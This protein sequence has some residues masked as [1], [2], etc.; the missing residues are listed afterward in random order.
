[1]IQPQPISHPDARTSTGGAPDAPPGSSGGGNT[2]KAILTNPPGAMDVIT[3]KGAIV[4]GS[5]KTSTRVTLFIQDKGGGASTGIQVYC[6]KNGCAQYAD[7][8]DTQ[9]GAVVDVSGKYT[10]FQG[11]PE[12]QFAT[13]TPTGATSTPTFVEVDPAELAAGVDVTSSG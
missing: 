5:V 8:G 1:D 12:L 3:V 9:R 6:P 11:E 13:V 10:V 7:L 2:V 4:V